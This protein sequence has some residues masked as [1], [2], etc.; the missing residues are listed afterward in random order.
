[1]TL[2][3][4]LHSAVGHLLDTFEYGLN[5]FLI[6]M[7][8]LISYSTHWLMISVYHLSKQVFEL[9]VEIS[10][11]KI[12]SAQNDALPFID[13]LITRLAAGT[14]V[15]SLLWLKYS[16]VI[17]FIFLKSGVAWIRIFKS[18]EHNYGLHLT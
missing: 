2:V 10:R 17:L 7:R 13:D 8:V 6:I 4:L 18:P 16:I 9:N 12:T 11:W 14:E 3:G 5:A 1:M 15:L